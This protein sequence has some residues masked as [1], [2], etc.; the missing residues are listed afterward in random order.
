MKWSLVLLSILGLACL[1]VA[2]AWA[3]R[4]AKGNSMVWVG[5]NGN[6]AQ[7]VGPSPAF[8]DPIDEAGIHVAVSRFLSDAW[9]GIVS[10]GVDAGRIRYEPPSGPEFK[11]SSR[12]WNVRVGFDRYAFINDEVAL[13]AGPGALYW[14]GREK[15]TGSP[16]YPEVS[17]I[18]FN[19]RLGMLARLAPHWALFG[20]I[21]QVIA[22]NSAKDSAAKLTWW[23][24]TH[25]GSVGLSY[26]L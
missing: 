25:E 9:A 18:G 16:D 13:Y 6:R 2:P 12:S 1:S 3:Q 14:K 24:N 11:I 8:L 7:T 23:S 17:Q 19:G 26:D 21:G 22:T 20:H 15:A 5:L 4:L 10:G